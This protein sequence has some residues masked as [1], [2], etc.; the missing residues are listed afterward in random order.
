MV[1]IV[2]VRGKGIVKPS[3]L[4]T[5]YGCIVCPRNGCVVTC[6]VFAFG[7]HDVGLNVELLHTV[8]GD[9]VHFINLEGS[10]I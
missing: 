10:K 9:G 8:V 7:L 1:F 6:F 3:F 4:G 2:L 5:W